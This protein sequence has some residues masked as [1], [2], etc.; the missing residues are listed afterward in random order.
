MRNWKDDMVSS[1][2]D[3]LSLVSFNE[4]LKVQTPYDIYDLCRRYPLMRNWKLTSSTPYE[5]Q[6]L[7]YPLMRNWK[8]G[9][10]QNS[11]FANRCVSFNEELKGSLATSLVGTINRYPLMRNW[12]ISRLVA[13]VAVCVYPLMR[14]WK[15]TQTWLTIILSTSLYPLMRNWKLIPDLVFSSGTYLV[16]FNEELKDCFPQRDP[17]VVASLYPLMR[18]WKVQFHPGAEAP[19]WCIL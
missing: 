12:K 17:C 4:E 13:R 5:A 3:A 10:C 1:P 9:Y 8:W 15:S 11:L 18:N 19:G 2:I 14:N 7:M 16:S 6:E